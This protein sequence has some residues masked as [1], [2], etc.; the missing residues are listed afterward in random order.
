MKDTDRFAVQ[1]VKFLSLMGRI[2]VRSWLGKSQLRCTRLYWVFWHSSQ[3]EFPSVPSTL[4]GVRRVAVSDFLFSA[5]LRV[6]NECD[7]RVRISLAKQAGI[8]SS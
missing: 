6:K 8:H 4:A 7:I 3:S 2:V 5:N 1:L